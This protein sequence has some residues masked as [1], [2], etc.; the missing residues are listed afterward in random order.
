[1]IKTVRTAALAC[2]L[3]L[4]TAAHAQTYSTSFEAPTFMPGDVLGQD[5]WGHLSNSPTRGAVEPAP[6]GT[7]AALG[8]QSLAI[9]TRDVNMFPVANHLYSPTISPPAGETGAAIEG[10]VQPA[11]NEVFLATLWYRTPTTPVVSTTA[12]GLFA[13]LDPS[14]K[15][16]A[17]NNPANRYAQVRLR[18]VPNTAAGLV[19][20]ELGWYA[21]ADTVFTF[22]TAATGLAWG[23]WYR[24]EYAIRTVDGL[25]GTG[26]N[27]LFT[28]RIF[29]RNG[30]MISSADASTCASTWESAYKTG[31]FGGGTL[32]RA[33]NGFDFWSRTGPND[34]LV[35]H[36][37]GISFQSVAMP[38]PSLLI[39]SGN[40]QQAFVGSPLPAPLSVTVANTPGDHARCYPV[41]F[42]VQSTPPG[43]VGAA[44]GTPTATPDAATGAASSSATLGNLPGTYTF[45]A[46]SPLL[47]NSPV[48]FSAE[49]LAFTPAL[50]VQKALTSAPANIVAGSVLGYTITATNAGN[51][52]LTGVTVA[53][54][55]LDTPNTACPNVAVNATCVLTGNYTV[56]AADVQAG[57]VSNTATADSA[58][59]APVQSSLQTPIA[60][61]DLAIA[62]AD[63]GADFLPGGSI[64]YTISVVNNGPQ[65]ATSVQVLDTLP[66]GV[67]FVSAAGAGWACNFNAGT[68]ACTR[69]TLAAGVQ[70]AIALVVSVDANYG[71]ASVVNTATVSN[72]VADP[73]PANNTASETTLAAQP[74]LSLQKALTSTP[75]YR[76]A[77]SVLGYTVTATNSGNI[78]LTNVTVADPA[79]STPNTACALVL[80]NA[81][82]VLTGNYTVSAAD[83]QAGSVTNTATADSTETAPVQRTLV[84]P[85]ARANLGIAKSDGGVDF[86]PGGPIDYVLTVSNAGPDAAEVIQVTDTLPAGVQFFS[87][88]GA[89]WSCTFAAGTVTCTRATLAAGAQA[90]IALS[91]DVVPGFAGAS[92]VNQASVSNAVADPVPANNTATDTTNAILGGGPADLRVTKSADAAQV[93]PGATIAYTLTVTNVGVA[94]ALGTVL[95]DATPAG[96]VFLDATAPCAG[97]FPCALGDL[98]NAASV[99]VVA[100]YRVPLGYQGTSISNTA[101]AS[102]NTPDPTPA[103]NAATMSVGVIASLPA[104]PPINVPS[105]G[106]WSLGA[107]ALLMLLGA[108]LGRTMPRRH[109]RVDTSRRT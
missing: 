33:I 88:T 56:T 82:C 42:A 89:G 3:L 71:G 35:G 45:T 57:V 98:A 55:L 85:I 25:S 81:T 21:N 60:R 18:N 87:A 50:A 16:P 61:A 94:T 10:V 40:N 1:M 100:R 97:G 99:T 7:P 23:E 72:A 52:A 29:D 76:V 46:A 36:I 70:A 74:G 102:A 26:P 58:E 9:R 41:N 108:G 66:A 44:V 83:V 14:T 32:P 68:V 11:T 84:T 69:P 104:P 43:A 31:N 64:A 47:A 91:V 75:Q 51:V 93:S 90:T 17:A 67:Q 109:A 38:D 79:L 103:D 62:K 54:P 65:D 106:A 19:S 28:L 95:S 77:G 37:D 30:V 2:G 20:V 59:T 6:A 39:A 24:F 73:V 92:I 12:N 78:A 5:G 13:E 15:G 86:V 63:S 53:D 48:V 101:S 27:D 34:Q 8:S 4:A 49:A 96:L 105:T 22:A 80:P 107:M